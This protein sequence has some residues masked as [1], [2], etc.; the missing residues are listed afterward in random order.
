MLP[1]VEDS[2]FQRSVCDRVENSI[3]RV[4]ELA[5]LDDFRCTAQEGGGVRLSGCVESRNAA[6]LCEIIARRVPGV[7]SVINDL[8]VEKV[9]EP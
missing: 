1:R 3:R 6:T 5:S 9:S 2:R 4:L 8:R 7:G